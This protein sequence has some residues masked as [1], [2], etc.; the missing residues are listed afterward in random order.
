MIDTAMLAAM[1]EAIS[2]LLP[3]TCDILTVTRT[4]DGYGGMTESIGTASAGV[5]CRLDAQLYAGMTDEMVKAERLL[6]YNRYMLS[7]PYDTTITT[8]NR[9][10]HNSITY[11]VTGV[12]VSQSWN[13][14]KRV[15][16]EKL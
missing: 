5:S 4:A 10:L 12:N 6:P 9:V 14:V 3:D 8:D 15:S 11:A 13:A 16:V 2:D 7:L 1:R